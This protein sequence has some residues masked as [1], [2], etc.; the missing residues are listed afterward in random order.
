MSCSNKGK[1]IVSS[2]SCHESGEPTSETDRD[3]VAAKYRHILQLRTVFQDVFEKEV[4]HGADE[5]KVK[6]RLESDLGRSFV[7]FCQ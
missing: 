2:G 1:E 6:L 5:A 7:H 4:V 3:A